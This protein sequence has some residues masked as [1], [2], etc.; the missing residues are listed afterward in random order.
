MNERIKKIRKDS[1]LTRK[2]FAE[3]LSLT[4]NFI[5]FLETGSRDP[6]PRT[7]SDICRTFN[8]NEHWLRTGDGI[9]YNPATPD[10]ELSK[11]FAEV[12]S[13]QPDSIRKRWAM[14]FSK[15]TTQQW[16][17]MA[18]IAEALAKNYKE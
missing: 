11:F 12:M 16:E 5:Y 10:E 6:S 13:D 18:D 8:V 17:N 15:L 4:E 1:G 9:P 7:I 14:A 3:R 2:A